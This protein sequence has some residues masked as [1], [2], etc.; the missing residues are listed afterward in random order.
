MAKQY[1]PYYLIYNSNLYSRPR[2]SLC[3]HKMPKMKNFEGMMCGKQNKTRYAKGQSLISSV[4]NTIEKGSFLIQKAVNQGRKGQNFD[5]LIG[6]ILCYT[7]LNRLIYRSEYSECQEHRYNRWCRWPD[8]YIY[9]NISK[10]AFDYWDRYYCSF[11]GYR[12]Y[13]VEEKS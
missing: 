4:K 6:C 8:K 9:F 2:A 13:C 12:V 7:I 1:P 11:N 5:V 3:A 10:L